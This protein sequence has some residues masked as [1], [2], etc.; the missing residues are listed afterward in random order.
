MSMLWQVPRY[1][2]VGTAEFFTFIGQQEFYYDQAP[3]ATRSMCS[4]LSLTTSAL[5]NYL[6]TLLVTAVTD[7]TT[8]NGNLGW[9]PDNLNSG[10]LD[11]YFWLLAVLE[12]L[13]L[14]V[15]PPDCKVVCLQEGNIGFDCDSVICIVYNICS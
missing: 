7:I 11:Y 4:V 3:D 2:I 12:S 10:H 13:E 15:V 6:S 1:F 9:I 5:G 8:R 14:W